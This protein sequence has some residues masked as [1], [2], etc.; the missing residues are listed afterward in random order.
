MANTYNLSIMVKWFTLIPSFLKL[1]RWP[2][3]LMIIFMQYALYFVLVERLYAMTGANGAI[4]YG[5]LSL[6]V[7]I[8]VLITAAGYIINDYFDLGVDRI[9][10]PDKMV[11]GKDISLRTGIILYQV[12]NAIAVLIG[13]YLAWEAGSW[14]LGLLFPMIIMLLWLYSLK[15]KRTIVWGNLAVA[16]MSAMVVLFIWL[17]EFFFLRKDPA[18]FVAVSPFL[19]MI[20][21]YFVF[22]S[23]CAF[24]FTFIREVIKDAEDIEGDKAG[25]LNTLAVHYGLKA[26]RKVALAVS[27]LS[28]TVIVYVVG[29][30]FVNEMMIP[31]I[32]F[33]IT[34]LIPLLYIMFKIN[35]AKEKADFR[36]LSNLMKILMLAGLIG[37][38]PIAM[39]LA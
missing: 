25:G 9:N 24:L 37:L 38:Q 28:A 1:I 16:F 4:G 20:T 39:S 33:L 18:S 19:R 3:L 10:K 36:M 14:R 22:Y 6:L 17:F 35:A 5:Y 13:F 30:F 8:T 11:L 15:Y 29:F 23:L 2:N 34:V 31:A 7:L 21:G 27:A 32:Y 26:S 12:I